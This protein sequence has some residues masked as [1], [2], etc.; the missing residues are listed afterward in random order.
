MMR[1]VYVVPGPM[2]ST[3]EGKA[4]LE[5]RGRLLREFAS[6]ETEVDI[7]DVAQGPASIESMYEEY[8]SIPATAELMMEMEAQGYD[9]AILGCFGD[10][11]LDAMRELLT[12]PVVGPGEASF[13]TAAM[14]GHQF[15]VITIMQSVV[16]PT[17]WQVRKAGVGEKLASVRSIDVPVLEL[18][19]DR[20]ATLERMIAEGR[21]AM[22]EDGADVLVLGCMTMGFLMVAED[23]SK[24]L[25]IPVVN[26]S[27]VS[28]KVAE[29]LVGARLTH[30]KRAYM[31]PPKLAIGKVKGSGELLVAKGE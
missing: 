9:A 13:L 17:R 8:I 18:A 26:P 28:L 2:G 25:G 19:R 12:M 31:T 5:R 21:K 7:I 30:S 20:E 15:S 29:M 11:G 6:P 1:I 4:E 14:L 23:M 10:P 24:A 3:P 16:A 22:E 27:R